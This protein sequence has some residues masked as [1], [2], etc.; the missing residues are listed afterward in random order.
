[1]NLWL[2]MY[3]VNTEWAATQAAA[4]TIKQGVIKSQGIKKKEIVIQPCV[5]PTESREKLAEWLNDRDV[6]G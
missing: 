5:V 4:K 6:K 2:V 1:M 3:N